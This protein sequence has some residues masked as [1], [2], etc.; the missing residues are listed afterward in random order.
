MPLSVECNI[1]DLSA[2]PKLP[3]AVCYENFAGHRAKTDGCH[4]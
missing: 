4:L 3:D 1:F 2:Q